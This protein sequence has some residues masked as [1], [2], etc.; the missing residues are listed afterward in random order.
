MIIIILYPDKIL[1]R[2]VRNQTTAY[3]NNNDI[4]TDHQSGFRQNHSTIQA[5][6]DFTDNIYEAINNNKYYPHSIYGFS[7]AFDTINHSILIRKLKYLGF[8]ENTAL[9]FQNYLTDSKQHIIANNK[10]SQTRNIICGVPQGSILGPF[11]FLL[12]INDLENCLKFTK[13]KL[14]ADDT[15]LYISTAL[16]LDATPML[17]VDLANLL[18]WCVENKFTINAK[19]TKYMPIASSPKK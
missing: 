5:I 18:S 11:L 7:K 4:I 16:E 15:V 9:W 17:N 3:L 2:I 10:T 6:A 13:Y 12:Y 8:S 1:E 14:Y 19:K